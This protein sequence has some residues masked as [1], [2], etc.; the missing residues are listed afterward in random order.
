MLIACLILIWFITIFFVFILERK[1]PI[2][3]KLWVCAGFG[4]F[5][6]AIGTD[7]FLIMG[8]K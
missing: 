6:F 3:D 7:I 8:D 4:M 1:M 5:L 2:K